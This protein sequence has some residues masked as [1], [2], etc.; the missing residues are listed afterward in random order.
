MIK[1]YAYIKSSH[2]IMH[3]EISL[4]IIDETMKSFDEIISIIESK[5][6]YYNSYNNELLDELIDIAMEYRLDVVMFLD[7]LNV[8]I[9]SG[10]FDEIRSSANAINDKLAYLD[11]IITTYMKP[12]HFITEEPQSKLYS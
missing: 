10:G 8:L 11:N 7:S 5:L 1:S 3:K 6:K 12:Q 9:N 4:K 2:N